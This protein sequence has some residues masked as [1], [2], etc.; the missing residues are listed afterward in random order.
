MMVWGVTSGEFLTLGRLQTR[1]WAIES[2]STGGLPATERSSW[3]ASPHWKKAASLKLIRLSNGAGRWECAR[4]KPYEFYHLR[5]TVVWRLS[6]GSR[7]RPVSPM[8]RLLSSR[9]STPVIFKL[10]THKMNPAGA[11]FLFL[12]MTLLACGSPGSAADNSSLISEGETRTPLEFAAL[13]EVCVL[14]V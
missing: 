13:G 10:Q 2:V 5:Q 9:C 14:L 8:L 6:L 3:E 7:S 4:W 1:L 12:V 11:P